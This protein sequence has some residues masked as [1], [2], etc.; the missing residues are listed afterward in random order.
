MTETA[1][2]A[3]APCRARIAAAVMDGSTLFLDLNLATQGQLHSFV[4]G[5]SHPDFAEDTWAD[6]VDSNSTAPWRRT[7]EEWLD[8]ELPGWRA[9]PWTVARGPGL[10][11]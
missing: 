7:P 11:D 6:V 8:K 3:G 1:N 2:T 5:I 4:H 9:E 10:G